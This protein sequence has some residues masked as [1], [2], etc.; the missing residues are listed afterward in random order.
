M[1]LLDNATPEPVAGAAGSE[2]AKAADPAAAASAT[3]GDA[4]RGAGENGTFSVES[5]GEAM[6]NADVFAEGKLFGKYGSW[7]DA[8][9]G[10]KEL[11]GKLREKSP[12][13]PETY[14]LSGVKIEG[15]PDIKFDPENPVAKVMLPAFKEAGIS[16]EAATKLA[17]VFM[18]YEAQNLIDPKVELAALGKD[19]IAMIDNVKTHVSAVAPKELQADIADITSTA[20]GIRVLNWLLKGR[21]EKT[22]PTT[23]ENLS[24]QKSAAEWATEAAE[25]EKKFKT[26]INGGHPQHQARYREL[27]REQ[28]KAELAEEA[29]AKK[30]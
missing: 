11:N 20:S 3:G 6:K 22:I 25:Y 13:A 5:F 18:A 1:S 12:G 7:D 14:D 26:E 9:K 10:F 19:G 30:S 27:R 15:Q 16:Q 8:A 24:D 4:A 23:I 29:K 17:G 2:T 21:T 28:G